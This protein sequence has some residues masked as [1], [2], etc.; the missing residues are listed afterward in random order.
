MTENYGKR[1]AVFGGSFSSVP[2]S[3]CAKD[4][5]R[6]H[7]NCD[8][9][10]YGIGGMGFS[11]KQT[12]EDNI[13]VQVDRAIADGGY[14]IY[15]LWASNNDVFNLHPVGTY[16]DYTS[17]DDF[18]KDKLVTQCGG[19]NY[20]IKTIFEFNPLSKIM[21]FTTMSSDCAGDYSNNPFCKGGAYEYVKGQIDCCKYWGV[22][23]LNQFEL[24]PINAYTKKAFVLED[25]VH[26]SEACYTYMGNLQARFIANH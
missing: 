16:R 1:I 20:C 23:C 14:D 13:Q 19:I 18:N 22:P 6:K 10:T 26:L 2:E 15:I 12:P 17:L 11:N 8:I 9:T 3:E 7:L 4:I 25:G 24:L 21:F 5:W